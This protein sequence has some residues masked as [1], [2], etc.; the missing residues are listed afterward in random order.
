MLVTLIEAQASGP[1][2]NGTGPR[3]L[4]LGF[5]RKSSPPE[6]YNP[7]L[8]FRVW[9]LGF[10]VRVLEAYVAARAVGPTRVSLGFRV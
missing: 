6:P 3:N 1:G 2:V 5:R 4:G 10:R 7:G 8:E 9:G